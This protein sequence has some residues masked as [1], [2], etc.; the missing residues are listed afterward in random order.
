MG[1]ELGLVQKQKHIHT[2]THTAAGW[3]QSLRMD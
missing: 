2:Q 3:E 1:L